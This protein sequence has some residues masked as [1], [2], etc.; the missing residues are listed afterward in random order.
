[1]NT[2][3]MIRLAL[4][5]DRYVLPVWVAALGLLPMSFASSFE[6][7]FPTAKEQLDYFLG[8]AQNPAVVSLQGLPYSPTIGGLTAQR[9]GTMY[10]IVALASIL[11]VTRH[12]R[13]EEESGRRELLAG[14]PLGRRAPLSA[15]LVTVFAANLAMGLLVALG[16]TAQGQPAAGSVALGA[17]LAGVGI[18][19]AAV[20]A[21]TAQLTENART[22]NGMAFAA[23]AVAFLLR[24]AGDSGG[25]DTGWS[26]LS[27]LSWL[28]PIGWAQRTR[29]YADERWWV[30]ALMLALAAALVAGAY[31]L[32]DRRDLGAGV[33]PTRPGPGAGDL[34]TPL[35]LAW[36]LHRGTLVAWTVLFA[37]MGAVIGGAAQSAADAAEDSGR[38]RD[39]MERLGGQAAFGDTYLS[40]TT[41]ILALAAAGYGISAA[42]RLRSE[43]VGQR[44][45]PILAAS[46]RRT[47]WAGSHLTFALLGPA[48]ALTAFGLSGGIAYGLSTD[49]LGRELP[50]VLWAALVQ[51]PA[52]WVL[53]GITLALFGLLP[54]Y[55]MLAWTALAAALFLGQFGAVLQLSHW[56]LDLSPFTH[57]PK[58]LVDPMTVAPVLLLL[59]LAAVLGAAGLTGFRRRDVG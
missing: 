48:V 7:L 53:V 14:A 59:A 40:A 15:A 17:A 28:S 38:L 21:G 33:L 29:P 36:R 3:A 58:V 55:A 27:W 10:V 54:R 11:T 57:T 25:G 22:A 44:A 26:W 51:L 30:F 31:A 43:E 49:D 32:A 2:G 47:R 18:V 35:A 42:L 5:R 9:I 39:I 45:E 52:V 4:R 24:L 13:T 46:V 34:A 12:T 16:L 20:A 50:R 37:A 41:G 19:F 8:T 1:M 56:A 23:L 6:G